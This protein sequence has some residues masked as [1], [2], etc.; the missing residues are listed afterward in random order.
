M[1]IFLY[2][3]KA[4]LKHPLF[5]LFCCS[6]FLFSLITMLG[7]GG[8]FDEVLNAKGKV[9]FLNSPHALSSI[10]FLLAKF[11]LFVIA[12][13]G[14]YGLYKDYRNNA[15]AFLYSFPISK[16]A[17]LNGKLGSALFAIIVVACVTILGIWVGDMMLGVANP[18]IMPKSSVGYL[19]TLFVYFVPTLITSGVLVFTVVG[20]TR[21]MYS[22]L[23]V[24]ICFALLQML[25]EQLFFNQKIVLALVDPFGQNAFQMATQH[26]D[27]DLK[28]TLKLPINY[29]TLMNRLLWF[30]IALSCYALFYKKFDFTYVQDKK[31]NTLR[32]KKSKIG[33]VNV[34]GTKSI[35]KVRHN[36]SLI[37]KLKTTI[38]LMVY[39]FGKIVKSWL[40][41]VPCLFGIIIIF[42][43]Q[44]RI[45]QTGEFNLL[46]LTR[47]FIG[48]PLTFYT[49]LVVISTFL[50]SGLSI[51]KAKQHKVKELV[52]SSPIENWQFIV[53]KIGAVGLMQVVQLILFLLVS[54]SIQGLN[55]HYQ[56][57]LDLYLYHL[58]ILLLP[59]LFV[60]NITSHLIH[61]MFTNVFVGLFVLLVLWLSAQ[62]LES[63][64]IHTN[65][66]KYNYLPNLEY[67]DFHGYGNQLKGYS[68]LQSYWLSFA[69]MLIILLTL[70][71]H[72][73]SLFSVKEKYSLAK[74]RLKTPTLLLLIL[75]T[76]Q[77]VWKGNKIYAFELEDQNQVKAYDGKSFEHYKANWEGHGS[78]EQ[79][80]IKD[81]DLQIDLYP[82]EERF[83]AK[84][85]YIMENQSKVAIDT[86][87]VRTGFDE[88]TQLHWE[89]QAQLVKA[90]EKLKTYLFKLNNTLYPGDHINFSF[91]IQNVTNGMF[92]RN[93]NVLKNGSFIRQDILP[94]IGYQFVQHEVSL[95]DSLVHKHN[96]FHRD[97]TYVNLRTR[98]STTANQTAIAPGTLISESLHNG[99]N[100]YEYRT[101][102]PV[103]FNFS[104]HSATFERLEEYYKD[105][106]IHL[107][108]NKGHDQ[109]TESMVAGLKAALKYNTKWF[110]KYPFEQVRIV[111][112]P[113][114]EGDYTATLTTNNIPTSEML[115]NMNLATMKDKI[116][117]PFYVM[118]H[119][120]THQWF[121]NK[122]LPADAEGAKMLT[123]SLTEYIT[124]NIYR[125]HFGEEMANVFL[126]AQ[127]NRYQRGKK[128]A[129]QEERP[130]YKVLSHQEYIAY[131]KGAIVFDKIS[132]LIGK[133]KLHS[134]LATFLE[135]YG[136]ESSYFPTTNDFIQLLKTK[137]NNEQYMR[138]KDWLTQL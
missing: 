29:L 47:L 85:Q 113:F 36:F 90:D 61:T 41:L 58:F 56:F 43:I 121:G 80:K 28:N 116:N 9:L 49:V 73:G 96:Y 16:S 107:Y 15:H 93:S 67:S 97:A 79:P 12:V 72:R 11:L 99:R 77:F 108:F 57:E 82:E 119:E 24:V 135:K 21:N 5:Y 115:F 46:P 27:V 74:S 83:V 55:G 95:T 132:S 137:T 18:K 10:S 105:I 133:D 17:Y 45:T 128:S 20:T 53:S 50:F 84:G 103:K 109:N 64:G 13:L 6:F 104:L 66:L 131:G 60:W 35:I 136:N 48:A 126:E 40:F 120:L 100:S 102:T 42:F 81:V 91:T 51:H 32:I 94:R 52:D 78:S 7:T 23:I 127:E 3:I 125:D 110:G 138:I 14:S 38:W 39:D 1:A 114:N 98:I 124:L 70:L 65:L 31:F 62:S 88:N 63:L 71:W 26:W 106:K 89:N 59:V 111:E 8:Y 30:I 86:V 92:S 122:I 123:E 22:G 44:L 129:K 101:G 34:R 75:F 130:L 117:L 54:V 68:L 112:Y 76:L 134:V 87:F 37:S 2:E 25:S 33:H 69:L 118:A 4:W 19:V